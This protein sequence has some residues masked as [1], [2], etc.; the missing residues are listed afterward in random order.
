MASRKSILTELTVAQL[1]E[2]QVSLTSEILIL[3]FGADW[4]KPCKMIAPAYAAYQAQC[5]INVICGDID[6]DE[7]MDLFMALKKQ[8]MVAGVPVFLAFFGGVKRDAWFIP[9]DSV[10]G[11]DETQVA[12]FFKRCTKKAS[13]LFIQPG[14]SYY[15]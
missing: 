1:Q 8:K 10:I 12:N 7:N 11:A 5:P 15:S 4:C 2:L 3:K 9:D 13:E 14:Y 6:I